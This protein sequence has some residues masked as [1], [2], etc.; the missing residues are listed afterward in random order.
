MGGRWFQ[1]RREILLRGLVSYQ[2]EAWATFNTFFD[3]FKLEGKVPYAE[4]EAWIGTENRKGPLWQLSDLCH[5]IIRREGYKPSI[6]EIL[7]DWTV[8]AIFHECL[9]IREELYQLNHPIDMC[10]REDVSELPEVREVIEE[11][12]RRLAQIRVSLR[13]GFQEVRN[14]FQ[15]AWKGMRGFLIIH[16]E[17]GLLMRYLVENR[18]TLIGL[19]G[20]DEWKNFMAAI[21]PHG[22]ADTWY[23]AGV[24]YLK[25]GWIQKASEA[26]AQALALYPDHREASERIKELEKETG[27]LCHLDQSQ[28]EAGRG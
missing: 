13:G 28:P 6:H 16:R 5:S 2:I 4:W 18:R 21:H 17:M 24:G 20:Q 9:K 7:L 26:F 12:E 15:R 11:W 27:A 22:E 3:C 23:Y 25:S 8:G 19:L 1:E 10:I 14:L